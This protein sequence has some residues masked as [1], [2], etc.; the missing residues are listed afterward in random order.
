MG[1]TSAAPAWNALN[2]SLAP[3][4]RDARLQL[5]YAAQFATALG[6]SYLE[7]RPDDSHT[8]LRWDPKLEALRSRDVGAPSHTVSVAVQPREL[9]LLVLVDG[10]IGER[11]P[12]HGSTI[13]RAEAELR[14]ALAP[15]G[16][17]SRKLTLR[18]HYDLPPHRVA[19][20]DPFDTNRSNDFA[21]LAHWYGNAS[22]LLEELRNRTNGAEV[23]C[24]PHHFDIATL[25][26][27]APGRTCGAGM[28]PGDVMY[29][30]PYYYVN[31]FPRP[32][33]RLTSMPLQGGGVWNTEDWFGA[34]LTGS[35]LNP[36]PSL[37]AIQVRAFLESAVDICTAALS[38]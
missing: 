13:A 6:I 8:N 35:C 31:A 9:I 38:G 14:S 34:V 1:T 5:H 33:D 3:H 18:R 4:L 28:L 15:A 29:P 7:H 30:E 2:P 26:T 22:I 11:I 21:E 32:D 20:N 16:L 36:D 19:R 25:V 37:Q 12:L 24:W 10:A 27:I 23:R 17:D